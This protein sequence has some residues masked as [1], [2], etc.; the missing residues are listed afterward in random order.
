VRGRDPG[1]LLA[2]PARGS[3][4]PRA[5]PTGSNVRFAYSNC[6]ARSCVTSFSV[7]DVD[8]SRRGARAALQCRSVRYSCGADRCVLRHPFVHLTAGWAMHRNGHARQAFEQDPLGFETGCNECARARA[9]NEYVGQRRAPSGDPI[10]IRAV[11]SPRPVCAR[12]RWFG[13][14]AGVP[15]SPGVRN[16]LTD[17]ILARAKSPVNFKPVDNSR[18]L[19]PSLHRLGQS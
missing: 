11:Q 5:G 9:L 16:L 10:N 12:T 19:Q 17:S 15:T 7:P 2:S 1:G 14:N 8:H 18:K 4:Q 3:P 6:R 13:A